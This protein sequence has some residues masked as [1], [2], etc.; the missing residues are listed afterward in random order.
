MMLAVSVTLD[1][2]SRGRERWSHLNAMIINEIFF[3]FLN[4]EEF[5]ELQCLNF[6][7]SMTFYTSGSDSCF[8]FY[9]HTVQKT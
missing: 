6:C 8:Y 7:F 1:P 4:K 2:C 5:N 9:I 3:F